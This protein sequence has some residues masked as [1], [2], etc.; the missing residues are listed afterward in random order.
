MASVFL[1][2]ARDDVARVRPLAQALESGGH[3][4][5]W[6][7]HIAGGQQ[8]AEEIEQALESADA[9]VVVW[10]D[11]SCRSSWVRDE[12][13]SARDRGR[14]IPVC[15]DGCTPPLG[16]RQFQA[17]DLRGWNG[18]S[19]S[20]ALEPLKH[21]VSAIAGSSSATKSDPARRAPP[22]T[23]GTP[24]E[25]L[26]KPKFVASAAALLLV[27]AALILPRLGLLASGGSVLPRVALGEFAVTSAD[28]PRD[29][30]R[31]MHDEIMAAFGTEN[32]V[33]LTTAAGAA[34]SSAAPFLLDGSIRK[35]ADALRF[36]LNLKATGSGT[37]LW[38]RA[39]DRAATD[40]LATRQVAQASSQIVR[41]GLWGAAS[42]PRRMPEEALAL[43]LN[44]CDEH[45][46]GSPDD[47][48]MVDAARR[49]TV[50]LPDFSFGWSALALAAAPLGQ[51]LAAARKAT[52]L[53]GHNPEGYMAEAWLLPT[54][55]F[56]EREALLRKAISVRPTECGCERSAYGDFLTSVGR[57]EEAVEQYERAHALLPLSPTVS[58]RLAHALFLSGRHEEG[59]R[60]VKQM[61]GV[62]PDAA[63]L[64]LVELK[65]AFWTRQYDRGL[66]MLGDPGL[67][68]T[69]AQ[70]E[71]LTAA[72]QAL[73]SNDAGLRAAAADRLRSMAAD[74]R[75]NDRMVVAALAALGDDSAAVDAAQRLIRARG[76][77][78]S[79]VLFDPNL[80]EASRTPHYQRLVS[81]LGLASY[82]RTT[83]NLPDICHEGS[84]PGFCAVA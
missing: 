84:R 50:A 35:D 7:Q 4:V 82:W 52:E 70:T 41:C 9:V 75:R 73:R 14:L 79:D 65:S 43:Y 77:M 49:V 5:W 61:L 13:A 62:W 27:A 8:Y 18:R 37:V 47:K 83:K 53:D 28:L 60:L 24:L 39:F 64:K 36:K 66:E 72:L 16:F 11:S 48:R 21:A 51:A 12:A 19:N 29:M 20:K 54:E 17:I 1:S 58:V 23:A 63:L 57:M 56:A 6:D 59:Q 68:L 33:T 74:P 38:S 26:R 34:G 32:A 40:P 80:A 69:S 55:R 10:S 42:Y 25:W 22:P 67:H 71:A 46:G 30:S 15:L 3:S 31:A 45:W 76:P 2:Y 78:V 81:E 44:Y